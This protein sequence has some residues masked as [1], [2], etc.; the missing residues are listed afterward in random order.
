MRFRHYRAMLAA[1]VLA[2]PIC[3][4]L[5]QQPVQAPI[6]ELEGAI[7][8]EALPLGPQPRPA[9]TVLRV[10]AAGAHLEVGQRF[11][12][13]GPLEPNG[14][15]I[16]IPHGALQNARTRWTSGPYIARRV[17]STRSLWRL[18]NVRVRD[19]YEH[20]TESVHAI[21]MNILESTDDGIVRL[22][23]STERHR[24]SLGVHGGH[25]HLTSY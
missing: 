4:V 14:D 1:S 17:P 10:E 8:Q 6:E 9:H 7:A 22:E 11:S 18:M 12:F 16:V 21:T 15:Y 13:I 2:A 5:A 3:D 20:P 19:S 24:G 25:A 23:L